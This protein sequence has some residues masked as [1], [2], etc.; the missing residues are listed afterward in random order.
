MRPLYKW[1][2]AATLVIHESD[3]HEQ[4]FTESEVLD[5][6][7]DMRAWISPDDEEEGNMWST[8]AKL[9]GIT[10]NPHVN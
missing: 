3:G 4:V 9:H 1:P 6:L 10:L 7:R 2:K 8:R 5:I